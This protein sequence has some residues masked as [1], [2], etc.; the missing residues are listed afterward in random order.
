V[1]VEIWSDIACPWCYVGKRRFEAALAKFEHRDGVRVTWRSFEL[2][3]GAPRER[4]G[5][6]AAH[7]AQKY[8]TTIERARE[9][10]RQMTDVAATEGLAFRFDIARSG[11]TFDAHRIVHLAEE[12]RLQDAMK[13]R[14]LRGYLTEGEL[15]SDHGTLVR[16]ATEVGLPD[17]EVR[18][19]L[20]GDRYAAEVREDERTAAQLGIGAV[21]TFVIE[22]ALG[23]SGAHPPE[24]LLDLLRQGWAARTP[25][26]IVSGGETCGID[27]C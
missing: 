6:R 1:H 7:L 27:G 12:H 8:G 10:E 18:E 23:A 17:D 24:A 5:D 16:L 22:R 4:E 13:E 3:P 11:V 20:A 19:T 2:D 14:L 15:M 25:V 26:S 21:P 9:M